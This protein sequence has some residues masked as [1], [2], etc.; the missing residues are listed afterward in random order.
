MPAPTTVVQFVDEQD[1][2]ALLLAELGQHRLQAFLELPPE[3]RAGDQRTHVER[4]D[5]FVLE[6]LR[7]LAVQN[8]LGE[9]LDDGRLPHT[10]FADQH[11]VVLGPPLQNLDGPANLV[12]PADHGI[13]LAGLRAGGEIHGVP[14]ER[15]AVFLGIRIAD[16]LAA[17]GRLDG[18]GEPGRFEPGGAQGVAGASGIGAD[19]REHDL[20]GHELVASA[21]R[22]PIRQIQDLGEIRRDA[23]LARGS[24]NPRQVVDSASN[25]GSQSLGIYPGGTEQ[26]GAA[27]VFEQR[28]EQVK[29][30][31][32]RVVAPHR[33]R[34]RL[35]ERRLQTRGYS[36]VSHAYRAVPCNSPIDTY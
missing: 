2:V 11:R 3:L 27:T 26:G 19:G 25:V 23:D 24:S 5:P 30:L 33:K 32:R 21:L 9:T 10:G 13:E 7:H 36:V 18:R 28:R 35:A 8:A 17:S 6:S 20:G 34:L 15:F 31:H 4:Q 14:V 29:R 12:V 1:D 22:F 16:R